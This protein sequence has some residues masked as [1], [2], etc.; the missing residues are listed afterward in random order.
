MKYHET[1]IKDLID[2]QNVSIEADNEIFFLASP[3]SY[4][5]EVDPFV[6]DKDIK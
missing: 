6:C 3:L 2:E 1:L 5:E 4:H